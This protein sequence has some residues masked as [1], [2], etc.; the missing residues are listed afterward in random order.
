MC[1]KGRGGP[2]STFAGGVLGDEGVD[3]GGDFLGLVSLEVVACVADAA[4]V[5]SRVQAA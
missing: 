2:T 4:V 3:L 5:L 1:A